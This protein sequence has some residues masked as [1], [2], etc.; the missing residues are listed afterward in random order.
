MTPVTKK[1]QGRGLH[2]KKWNSAFDE[3]GLLKSLIDEVRKDKDL[4]IQIRED[5][6]NVY[7]KGGN[8][9]K[10]NSENSFE[11]DSEYYKGKPEFDTEEKRKKERRKLLDTLKKNRDYKTFL[12]TMKELMDS[13]WKKSV[14]DLHEKDTQHALC[15]SNTVSSDYTVIDLEFQ[16]SK[17]C[18]YSYKK[19]QIPFGRFVDKHKT[20]PRFDIIAV[21][22]RDHRLCV[23]ELKSGTDA[24]YRKSGIGDHAD[25]FEGSIGRNPQAF[26][27]EME[28]LVEDKKKLHLLEE[29]FYMK[30]DDPEFLYAYAFTTD[31]ESEKEKERQ[32]FENEQSKANANN[33]KVI[34]L[35][36]RDYTLYD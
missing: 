21:R 27:K 33:Y 6:L 9:V 24:L 32:A 1:H 8:L 20:A 14:R 31:D 18:P 29:D 12:S 25:S 4:V 23:I 10:V 7:Y 30:D 16:V 5:Y 35:K 2:S 3:N 15:I 34:Y 28:G 36:K 19:T 17:I 11:F 22:N 26:V 13:F